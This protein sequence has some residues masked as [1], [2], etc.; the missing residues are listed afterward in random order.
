MFTYLKLPFDQIP[1]LSGGIAPIYLAL[2]G[3]VVFW[4]IS[5]SEK[6]KAYYFSKYNHDT[7]WLRFIYMTKW[8]GFLSMGLFPLLFLLTTEPNRDLAYYG[9]NFRA[10][11]LLFN[12]VLCIALAAILI[13]L[14]AFSAKKPK[15]LVNYPQIRARLWDTKTFRLNLFGWVLY[16]LGYELL[17]RGILLFPLVE[18]YG[19]WLAIAVNV[20]LYSATHIPKGL[21]ETI[22]AAP[23][24]FLLCILTLMA[25]NIWIAFIVHV[26]MAWTNSLTALKYHPDIH[27]SKWQKNA[28]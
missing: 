4:F 24:G 12:L 8:V 28:S 20:A 25:G 14:A 7:A 13:P 11:T 27:Y 15:N 18:A 16:L 3:F 22:G 9:L 19:I 26:I 5:K 6:I 21:D 17:F 23:L 1:S 2:I 10:D